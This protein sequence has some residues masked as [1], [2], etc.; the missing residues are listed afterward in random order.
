MHEKR[1]IKLSEK[2]KPI[3]KTIDKSQIWYVLKCINCDSTFETNKICDPCP[4]CGHKPN[5]NEVNIIK[6]FER[7]IN[8]N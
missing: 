3:P 2:E 6:K 4:N 8:A 5:C 1:Y 7:P